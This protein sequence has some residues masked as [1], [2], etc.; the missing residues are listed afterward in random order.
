MKVSCRLAFGWVVLVLLQACGE[1]PKYN[2]PDTPKVD[3][4]DVYFGEEVPDPYRWLED[5]RAPEVEKWVAAQNKV[6]NRYLESICFREAIGTQLRELYNYER[7]SAPN[8]VG[9]RY[10]Y[11]RNEGLQKQAV[12][13]VKKGLNGSERLFINPN[14]LDPNGTTAVRLLGAS[15]DDKLI[16]VALSK[17]GSDWQEIHIR[18]IGRNEPLGDTLKWVKFTRISWRDNKSFYYTGFEKPA[19]GREFSAAN[20]RQ[21][22]YLHRLGTPQN[23]DEVV[24]EEPEVQRRYYSISTLQEG[25]WQIL[26][27]QEG[28]EGN[29]VYIKP[30]DNTTGD[31]IPIRTGFDAKTYIIGMRGN[32]LFALTNEGAE[33]YRLLQYTLSGTYPNLKLEQKTLVAETDDRLESAMLVGNKLLLKY[34]KDVRNVVFQYS[35][36]GEEEKQI[37]LPENFSIGMSAPDDPETDFCFF[38][39]TGFVQ[40]G[41]IYRYQIGQPEPQLYFRPKLSYD[42][43]DFVTRQMF[44]KSKDGT[45]IPMFLVHRRGLDTTVANPTLLYGYG[46]FNISVKPRFSPLFTQFIR[47]GG[48]LAVAN[49]RGGGEYGERWHK[50]GML[51]NKQN[52]FDDFIAAAEFLVESG[53]TER[54]LLAIHGR[55]N[56]GLLVGAV[57]TQRPELCKVALPEVGV[58]DMLRFHK[59]TVGWGWTPEYGSAENEEQYNVLKAYS[60]YHNLQPGTRYPATLVLTA[61]HDDRVVPAHSFKFIARLQEFHKGANPVMIRI[62]TSAGH[63]AGKPVDMKIDHDKDILAFTYENMN[64]EPYPCGAGR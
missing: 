26:Y 33:M 52:V 62:E 44:Y 38:S 61:D 36:A 56:G 58:L 45:K 64:L 53:K 47:D 21:K 43:T 49:I 27:K 42:P 8:V 55:S 37:P 59:F 15:P 41:S 13:Y 4:V 31:F 39:L 16:G 34:L 22:V 1:T 63:G 20:T 25:K 54:D 12:W 57:M 32:R 48:I 60:P 46:G 28:T 2:Y 3:S 9:E 5:D 30:G 23:E 7:M 14:E 29:E 50:A 35:L 19:E 51:K 24:F 18:D 11:T 17:A 40:P 10:F 6:T